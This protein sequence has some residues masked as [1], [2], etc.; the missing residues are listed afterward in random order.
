M[1]INNSKFERL[2]HDPIK[3][4]AEFKRW[5]KETRFLINALSNHLEKGNKFVTKICLYRQNLLNSVTDNEED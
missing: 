2:I 5:E 4:A 3:L 1:R